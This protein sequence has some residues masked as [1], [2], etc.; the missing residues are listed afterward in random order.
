MWNEVLKMM[1]KNDEK[2]MCA[3]VQANTRQEIK[4]LVFVSNKFL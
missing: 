3:G 4:D 2:M 1:K